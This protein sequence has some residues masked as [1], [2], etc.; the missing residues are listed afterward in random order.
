VRSRRSILGNPWVWA[1]FVGI[2]LVTASR[3]LLRFD[4]PP[5]PVIA[6]VPEFRVLDQRGEPF[7]SEQLRGQ[8]YV[9]GFFFT[10]CR[11]ICPLLIG[12]LGRLEERLL[13]E[14]FE[15]VR[16]VTFT[17]DPEHDTPELLAAFGAERGIDPA[18]WALLSGTVEELEALLFEGFKVPMGPRQE[19][20]DE[21]IDIAH[22]GKLVLVDRSGGVRGYYSTDAEGMDELFHRARRLR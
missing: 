21:L 20:A 17:V 7:G 19:V 18:R 14:N 4:P 12:A 15:D 1:F 22:S 5:P 16:I 6:R 8:V 2:A 13:R 3:P 10:R 11:T 9:A